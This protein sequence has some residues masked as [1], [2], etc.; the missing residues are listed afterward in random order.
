VATGRLHRG[1]ALA[2]AGG[3]LL[4]LS[5]FLPW[6][7]F[8]APG[9]SGSANAWEALELIDLALLAIALAALGWAAALATG[10]LEPNV[11]AALVVA[12]VGL[13]GV[14]LVAFR[15]ID[16][17]T[18]AVPARFAGVLDYELRVGA[19]VA[20]VGAVGIAAGGLLS[21]RAAGLTTK[22]RGWR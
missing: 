9:A 11:V 14:G 21:A 4:T 15:I 8:E 13:I 7:G 12:A 2:G 1:G 19:A 20:L 3:A 17:P 5:L 18:P 6:Y 22:A 10:A 16:L